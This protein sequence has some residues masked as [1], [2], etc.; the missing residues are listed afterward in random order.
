[1][2][3]KIRKVWMDELIRRANE[4]RE[5]ALY[6]LCPEVINNSGGVVQQY[7]YMM[8][9]W[10]HDR[11]EYAR[12]EY[13]IDFRHDAPD[14]GKG[15]W[16]PSEA[17]TP[18]ETWEGVNEDFWRGY[19]YVTAS[20]SESAIWGRHA[21]VRLRMVH[22]F[23]HVVM[24]FRFTP[25]DEIRLGLCEAS[26][27][28]RWALKRFPDEQWLAYAFAWL[29][30]VDVSGQAL[31]FARSGGRFLNDQAQFHR[32]CIKYGLTRATIGRVFR[33]EVLA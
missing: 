28:L 32:D 30:L 15:F 24:E 26:A 4:Y 3:M 14:L 31:Y 5:R 16:H 17:G 19:I 22:D 20:G 18:S 11:L 25:E 6:V 29:V 21:N 12:E 1:M 27:A 8:E 2:D 13:G 10:L 9:S 23:D 7:G 33:R